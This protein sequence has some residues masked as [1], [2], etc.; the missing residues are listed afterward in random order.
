METKPGVRR[1]TRLNGEKHETKPE[2]KTGAHGRSLMDT[3]KVSV[4]APCINLTVVLDKNPLP[5]ESESG[6]A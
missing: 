1:S 3:S 4:Q 6:T 2:K 5:P